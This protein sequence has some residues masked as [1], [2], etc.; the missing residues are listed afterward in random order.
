VL[1]LTPDDN[2]SRDA[3]TAAEIV[4]ERLTRHGRTPLPPYITAP[5]GDRE[6]YQ[7]VYA[8][9]PGS[10]AAPTAGLHFTPELLARIRSAG[11]ISRPC[12][13]MLGWARFAR[14]ERTT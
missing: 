10:A 14:S 12:V 8:R 4:A 13:W 1:R 2:V 5:L 6:R 7:T 11:L 3:A 9:T